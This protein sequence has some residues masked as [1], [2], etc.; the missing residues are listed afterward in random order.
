MIMLDLEVSM[1]HILIA[2]R[3]AAGSRSLE[4]RH[5]SQG[6]PGGQSGHQFQP[7]Q[8]QRDEGAYY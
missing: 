8:F 3:N 2:T 6:Q 4:T 1:L 5:S 7:Q